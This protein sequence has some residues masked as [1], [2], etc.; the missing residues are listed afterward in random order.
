V[1]LAC[2]CVDV[3][4]VVGYEG[5]LREYHQ[6]SESVVERATQIS[7]AAFAAGTLLLSAGGKTVAPAVAPLVFVALLFCVLSSVPSS[8]ARRGIGESA[9]L[10]STQ[11][12][13]MSFSA[14]LLALAIAVCVDEKLG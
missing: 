13:C 10:E 12:S 2:L 7:T 9:L 4:S 8:V 1:V 5:P 14:G 3:R 11:H 6:A